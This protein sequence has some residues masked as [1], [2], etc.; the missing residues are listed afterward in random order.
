MKKILPIIIVVAIVVGGGAFFAGYKTGQGG[1]VASRNGAPN[2]SGDMQGG[3]P[4]GSGMG[5][6]NGGGMT[7]GEILS[8]DD[9]SIT[10][11]L[12]NGGSK[13]IFYSE[14]TEIS[15]TIDGIVDDLEIGKTVM[16]SGTTNQDGSITAKTVQLRSVVNIPI[17]SP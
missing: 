17:I 14:V 7:S 15:K 6:K 4:S 3:V 12:N 10:I 9:N 13:I 2:I 8:K 11:K 1:S 16:I 5:I